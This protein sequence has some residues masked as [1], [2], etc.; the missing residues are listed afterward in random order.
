MPDGT[1]PVADVLARV[2]KPVY[3][4]LRPLRT[5]LY[6]MAGPADYAMRVLSGRRDAPPLWLRRH[7]GPLTAFERASG[8]IAALIATHELMRDGARVLDIGCGCG[9]MVPDF[10]RM[11]GPRGR[12]LG[13]DVHEASL[14]WCRRHFAG[15]TRLSFELARV[16][17]PYSEHFTTPASE[18]RFPVDTGWADFVLAKSV[19]THLLELDA[20]QYLREI[21][22]VLAPGGRAL[23]SAFLTPA[24]GQRNGD[25]T[26]LY[27]FPFG[28]SPVWWM[29]DAR[30]TAGVAYEELY[31]ARMLREAGLETLRLMRGYWHGTGIAPNTQDL[32]VVTPS[33]RPVPV[34][35]APD[36]RENDRRGE[37]QEEERAERR[38]V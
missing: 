38:L 20:R 11:I 6:W 3:R 16:R 15:D 35:E 29:V 5:A 7:V 30:P 31:F 34:L 26:P 17:T 18:F 2:P 23:L 19:F 22:R 25:G 28:G 9:A 1:S 36:G 21:R 32:L 27:K 4:V 13:F 14:T 12:Y 10:R 37:R 8:E 33:A 24:P